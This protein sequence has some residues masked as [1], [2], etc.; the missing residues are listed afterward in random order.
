MLYGYQ[1]IQCI[2]VCNISSIIKVKN[3]IIIYDIFN[4]IRDCFIA[5]LIL[6]EAITRNLVICDLGVILFAFF[7]SAERV[8][9]GKCTVYTE[10]HC[11]LIR[12]ECECTSSI[13]IF[14]INRIKFPEI[15]SL[16]ILCFRE[17]LLHTVADNITSRIVLNGCNHII[18]RCLA[19][20]DN[21]LC[22]GVCGAVIVI[23]IDIDFSSFSSNS[24]DNKRIISSIPGICLCSGALAQ[25]ACSF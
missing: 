24:L 9:C 17:A 21:R 5:V 4:D 25:I 10:A 19:V 18:V 15:E 23:V 20:A 2:A 11:L 22:T 3:N 8:C 6:I 7:I 14:R 12:I 13:F 1:N 16:C